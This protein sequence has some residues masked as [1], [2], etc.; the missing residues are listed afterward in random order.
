MPTGFG[1]GIILSSHTSGK[2][3]GS[4]FPDARLASMLKYYYHDRMQ[5]YPLEATAN[6]DSA[7]ND[8]LPADFTDAYRTKLKTF[9]SDYEDSIRLF[10]RGSPTAMISSAPAYSNMKW[11]CRRRLELHFMGSS[12]LNDNSCMPSASSTEYRHSCSI[13]EER[14]HAARDH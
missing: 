13:F 5:L 9:F 8:L 7:Y 1:A 3:S 12:S 6:G 2:P 11:M 4:A 10:K 14:L